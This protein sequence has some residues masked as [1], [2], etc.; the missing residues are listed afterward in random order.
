VAAGLGPSGVDLTR[1]VVAA[2]VRGP[3]PSSIDDEQWRQID[4]KRQ[5]YVAADQ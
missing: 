1:A 5:L 2:V 3:T 4:D